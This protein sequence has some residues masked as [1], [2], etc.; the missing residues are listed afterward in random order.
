M[1]RQR[2]ILYA[3]RTS[4]I[5]C[6][7][8]GGEKVGKEKGFFNQNI[9]MV[10]IFFSLDKTSIYQQPPP[11]PHWNPVSSPVQNKSYKNFA[12]TLQALRVILESEK[13][14]L[15]KTKS[16]TYKKLRNKFEKDP[17]INLLVGLSIDGRVFL[18]SV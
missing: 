12:T 2:H 8:G 9:Y 18:C 7:G 5:F 1:S 3:I 17:F 11:R 6:V 10:S 16:K 13:L 4:K 15:F 14:K